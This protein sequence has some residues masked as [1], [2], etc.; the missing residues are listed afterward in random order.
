ML[1]SGV[2]QVIQLYIYMFKVI[3]LDSYYKVLNII[4]CAK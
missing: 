4:P 1:V 2:Q 3:F